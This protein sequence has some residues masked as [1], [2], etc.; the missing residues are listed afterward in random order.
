[1]PTTDSPPGYRYDYYIAAWYYNFTPY[2][3]LKREHQDLGDDVHMFQF[4]T[5]QNGCN[6]LCKF[7][8][9]GYGPDQP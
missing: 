9:K 2:E 3:T 1:M 5:A 7:D 8:R 4:A 6:L